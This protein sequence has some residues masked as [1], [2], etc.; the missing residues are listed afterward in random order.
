MKFFVEHGVDA[1]AKDKIL[2]SPL[3]YTAR[4]G[5]YL[6]SEFLIKN[7]CPINDKDIYQQTPVY[8]SARFLILI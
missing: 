3:Y 5:K 2:Q 7:G 6:C 8:Y 4:E 1:T